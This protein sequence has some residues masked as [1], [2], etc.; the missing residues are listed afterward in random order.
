MTIQNMTWVETLHDISLAGI[1]FETMEGYG[2]INCK[3]YSSFDRRIAESILYFVIAA[4]SIKVSQTLDKIEKHTPKKI[5][6]GN[7]NNLQNGKLRRDH[8][9]LDDYNESLRTIILF[10]YTIVN[11][12]ELGYKVIRLHNN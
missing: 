4:V 1:D 6:N 7:N 3:K 12:I 10:I 8:T 2:G 9:P 11:G 5:C